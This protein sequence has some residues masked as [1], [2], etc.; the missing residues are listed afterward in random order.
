MTYPDILGCE[1]ACEVAAA[2]LP[3]PFIADYPGLSPVN[4]ADLVGALLGLD[5]VLWGRAATALAFWGAV[6]VLVVW[7]AGR[8]RARRRAS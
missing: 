3:V 8:V 4:S 5:R 6:S 7:A 2:G 1:R